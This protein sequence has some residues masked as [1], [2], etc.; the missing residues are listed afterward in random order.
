MPFNQTNVE[1]KQKRDLTNI[2]LFF[3]FNQTNVELKQ[4][5]GHTVVGFEVSF[6]QTNVELKHTK[7]S[8]FWTDDAAF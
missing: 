6:N 2:L 3:T 4:D 8:F 7:I 1:L 5:I